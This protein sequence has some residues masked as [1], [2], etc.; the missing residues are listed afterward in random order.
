[1]RPLSSRTVIFEVVPRQQSSWRI[2]IDD[3]EHPACFIDREIAIAAASAHARLLHLD[4][5]LTTEVR[6]ATSEGKAETVIRF[7]S[8]QG[9]DVSAHT[10]QP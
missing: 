2:S 10:S 3:I 8:A 6:I 5:G 4:A 9:R 7:D 1:V